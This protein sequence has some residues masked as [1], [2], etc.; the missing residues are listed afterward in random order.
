M[1]HKAIALDTYVLKNTKMVG[2][3]NISFHI[4]KTSFLFFPNFEI[5][6]KIYC[7]IICLNSYIELEAIKSCNKD[8]VSPYTSSRWTG[9]IIIML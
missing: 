4:H 1:S 9:L 6:D 3:L 7:S 2:E 5:F 8:R